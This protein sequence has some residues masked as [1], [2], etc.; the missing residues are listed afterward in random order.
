MRTTTD[1]FQRIISNY[2]TVEADPAEA[3]GPR[4]LEAA[5][6]ALALAFYARREHE[7]TDESEVPEA[8][9]TLLG[10]LRHLFGGVA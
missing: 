3:P 7:L 9:E 10:A 5:R 4:E 6:E 2:L 1:E 8:L